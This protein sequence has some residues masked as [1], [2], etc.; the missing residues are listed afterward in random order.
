MIVKGELFSNFCKLWIV[1]Q[2]ECNAK[3]PMEGTRNPNWDPEGN[4][5]GKQ[6]AWLWVPILY[7]TQ[8]LPYILVISVSVILYKR[9]GISNKEIGYYTSFLYLPWVLK[10]L[11]SPWID[12]LRNNRVVFLVM[13]WTIALSLLIL[14]F[15]IRTPIFLAVS[16]GCFWIS[17]IASATNDIATDGFYLEQLSEKEQSF[18]V[19]IRSTF[20][21]IA[22]ISGEGLLVILA[23]Y[24]EEIYGD[25]AR[26]WSLSMIV[27]GAVLLGLAL[28]NA[29]LTPRRRAKLT[30]S[31]HK[32]R[33]TGDSYMEQLKG[34]FR[35]S[36]MGWALA[37]VLTYRLGEGLLVKMSSPFLLDTLEQGGMALTTKELGVIKGT[38]GVIALSIGGIAGGVL[39]SRHGLKR[40]LI[41]M[42]LA[43]NL[44]NLGYAGLA[45]AGK[46]SLFLVSFV[47]VLEQLGY[48]FGFAAFL[49]YLI[50]LSKGN[51]PTSHYALATG[52]M[53]LGLMVPGFLSGLLQES[54][55]YVDFF[56]LVIVAALPSFLIVPRLKFPGDFGKK[57]EN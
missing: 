25:P 13:Q 29:L 1:H 57:S 35:K 21:R 56:T 33:K 5:S 49:M 6:R 24:W 23:G 17:A 44:P 22:F 51:H 39:I 37:F 27:S 43:L 20:Y 26:A 7:L 46:A 40:W 45:L 19:G 8:G 4:K 15:F 41:P 12:Q 3:T 48:G 30:D 54:L 31:V 55:G 38:A 10:P 28:A 36:N 18:Y 50:Y 47:V 14:G 16:L 34:F 53:A 11:W 2:Y 32:H 52:F 42:M 9:L